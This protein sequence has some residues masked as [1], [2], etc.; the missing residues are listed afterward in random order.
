MNLL[1]YVHILVLVV[2]HYFADMYAPMT[3]GGNK[4]KV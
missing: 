4:Y 2:L 3:I 1:H